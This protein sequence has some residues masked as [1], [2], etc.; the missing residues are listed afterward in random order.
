[1][2]AHK[3]VVLTSKLLKGDPK[4]SYLRG[5]LVSETKTYHKLVKSKQ[6]WIALRSKPIDLFS[7]VVAVS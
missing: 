5:K 2:D 3:E 1:M 4:N 6:D 7:V